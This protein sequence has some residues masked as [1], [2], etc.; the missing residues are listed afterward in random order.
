MRNGR[1]RELFN[2]QPDFQLEGERGISTVSESKFFLIY[3]DREEII[4]G[5]NM[6]CYQIIMKKVIAIT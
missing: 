5:R 2:I 6:L 3:D 4:W 1:L